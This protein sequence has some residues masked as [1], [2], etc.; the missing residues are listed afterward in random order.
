[1]P[2]FKIKNKSGLFWQFLALFY[3]RILTCATTLFDTV[4]MP[5]K[6]FSGELSEVRKAALLLHET[7]HV[8]QWQ[9]EGI[10]FCLL[11]LLSKSHRRQYEMEAYR[12]QILYVFRE[13]GGIDIDGWSKTISSLYS[14][15]NFISFEDAKKEIEKWLQDDT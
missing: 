3:P 14:I 13:E 8:E 7:T 1:M 2:D 6:Y 4:Y 11:W 5:E 12:K 10:F 15:F 9:N